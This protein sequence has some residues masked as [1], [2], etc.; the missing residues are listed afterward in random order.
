MARAALASPLTADLAAVAVAAVAA[1]LPR[2]ALEAQDL[3]AVAVAAVAGLE[4]LPAAQV[5][6]AGLGFLWS[7]SLDNGTQRRA[8]DG[9]C[10]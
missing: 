4:A 3:L 8:F 1:A 5:R 10:G 9:Y 7:R 2:A 6:R